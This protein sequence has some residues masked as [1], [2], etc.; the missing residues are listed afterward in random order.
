[1]Y[2]SLILNEIQAAKVSRKS[3]TNYKIFEKQFVIYKHYS[4][5]GAAAANMQGLQKN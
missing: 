1:M 4:L 5:R 3:G 2:N